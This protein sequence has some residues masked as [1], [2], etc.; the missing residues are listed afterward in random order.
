MYPLIGFSDRDG[1]FLQIEVGWRQCQ[2]L[3]FPHTAPVEKLESI[4]GFG[5]IHHSIGKFQVFFLRP[6]Q[7]FP[8]LLFSKRPGFSTGIFPEIVILHSM[9][10]DS[11]Q[12]VL[13]GAE[14]DRRVRLPV[15]V[16]EPQHL[17]LPGHDDLRCNSAHFQLAEVGDQLCPDDMILCAPGILFQPC[18][19][20]LGIVLHKAGEGHIQIRRHLVHL[21]TLPCLGFMLACKTP[22]G[23][24]LLL[25]RPIG[26]AV[27]HPPCICLVV[28]IDAHPAAPPYLVPFP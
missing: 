9:A 27:D 15:L 16:P 28:L 7:H 23:T 11:C 8:G 1:A 2:Q 13:Y 20:I 19:Q 18:L 10:E 26:V 21:L 14:I 3:T 6:E 5:L 4:E 22:L 24:L 25:S 12:L 17:I